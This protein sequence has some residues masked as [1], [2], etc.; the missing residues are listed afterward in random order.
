MSKNKSFLVYL[1]L[2]SLIITMDQAF[3]RWA[4]N[5]LQGGHDL[6]VNSWLNFSFASNRGISWSLF[7]FQA[8]SLYLVL[9]CV[10]VLVISGF[11][12]YSVIQHLN[13]VLIYFESLVIGGAISNVIDRINH[14]YVIDFIDIHLGSWHWATFNVADMFIVI[15]VVGMMLNGFYKNNR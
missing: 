1:F 9:T 11:F 6:M 8:D 13:R 7:N 14:G 5:V 2:I 10:I 15:G 12:I 4:F 3:K